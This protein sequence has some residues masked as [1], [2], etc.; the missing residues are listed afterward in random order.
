LSWGQ[1]SLDPNSRKVNYGTHLLELAP[2]EYAILELFLRYPQMVFSVRA[3][4]DHAWTAAESPGEEA[5]RVHIKELRQKLTAVRAP[6]DWI[7]TVY[8]VGYRLNP[9]YAAVVPAGEKQAP[10]VQQVAELKSVNEELCLALEQLRSTQEELQRKN[11]E[12][13]IAYQTIEQ[14][15]QH[16]QVARDQAEVA[17]KRSEDKF[18]HF[19]ENT[20][21]V[22]W[23]A[24]PQTLDKLYV[25]PAYESIWGRSRQSLMERPT[26]WMEAIYPDDLH[27]IQAKLEHQRQGESTHLEYRILGPDGSIR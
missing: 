8:R 2:K 5:V 25:S 13:E 1:L 11:Q 17:L 24:E 10:T 22:I 3:I 16:L 4:L 27:L 15:R 20:H 7:K 19:A 6:K 23:M 21:A 9:M 26:S 14:D 12:L 18:R